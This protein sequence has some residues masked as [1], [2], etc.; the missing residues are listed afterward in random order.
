MPHRP[1]TNATNITDA[2]VVANLVL[3]LG[4]GVRGYVPPAQG[5]GV[6]KSYVDDD[7]G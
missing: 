3:G 1:A 7:G 2:E 5:G 6:L 4:L